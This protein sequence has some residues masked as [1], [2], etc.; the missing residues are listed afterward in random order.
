MPVAR[1]LKAF[2]DEHKV[3]YHV[4]SHHE[5]FTSSEIAQALHVPGQ[6]LAKVVMV[7]ADGK[8]VMAVVTANDRVDL[9]AL[10][11]VIGAKNAKL[12]T[13]DDFKGTFPDCEVG[14]MPPFGNL[15]DVPVFAD[16][17][18]T[19][20]EEIVFE[21]GNHKEAVK[22]SYG[23]FDRLVKPKVAEIATSPAKAP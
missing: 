3:K 15:Y 14:A 22:L 20:D 8:L 9:G 19:K 12:A 17:A 18:L 23:D 13:E 5:R 6:E 11:G 7:N 1:K 10:K 4:L 21:A 2:L 16:S